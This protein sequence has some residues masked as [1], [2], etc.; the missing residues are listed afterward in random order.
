MTGAVAANSPNRAH[1]L[2]LHSELYSCTEELTIIARNLFT[3]H[4]TRQQTVPQ[5]SDS[6]QLVWSLNRST[7]S[8]EGPKSYWKAAYPHFVFSN[9]PEN[10]E[11]SKFFGRDG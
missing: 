6:G 10:A 4:V 7:H 9:L 8:P 3:S 2:P 5:L 11:H 1:A